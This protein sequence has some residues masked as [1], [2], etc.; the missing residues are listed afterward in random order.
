MSRLENEAQK[1]AYDFCHK[2]SNDTIFFA[3]ASYFSFFLLIGIEL[4]KSLNAYKNLL[5]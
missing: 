2:K 3:D 5:D 1:S 4:R